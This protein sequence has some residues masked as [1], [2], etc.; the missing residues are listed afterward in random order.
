MLWCV[1]L[2]SQLK[3]L[4]PERAEPESQSPAGFRSEAALCRAAECTL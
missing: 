4:T 1:C 2:S 3:P